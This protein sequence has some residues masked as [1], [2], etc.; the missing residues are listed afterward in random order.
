MNEYEELRIRIRKTDTRRYLVLANGPVAAAS[1]ITLN[2]PA[3]SYWQ[4]FHQLLLEELGEVVTTDSRSTSERARD[5]GRDLFAA[6]LP[7]PLHKALVESRAI[8]QQEGKHLRL[9]F[10][11]DADLM[12]LPLELLCAP[13]ADPLGRLALQS[14]LSIARSLEGAP[15]H[16]LRMPRT[17]DDRDSVKLLAVVCSPQRLSSLSGKREIE[18]LKKALPPLLVAL[19]P[20]P[21]QVLAGER[22]VV[23]RENVRALLK[24]QREPCALLIVAHGIYDDEEGCSAVLMEREDRTIDRLSGEI[25]NGLLTQAS[26]LRFVLLNLCLGAKASAAEPFSGLAQRLIAGGIPAVVAMQ[27]EVSNE[28]ATACSPSLFNGI[29]ENLIVDEA[30][31]AARLAM[32]DNRETRIE[33]ANPVLFLHRDFRHGWLFKVQETPDEDGGELPDPLMDCRRILA[34]VQTIPNVSNLTSA[35]R[36]KKLQGDWDGALRFAMAG[37]NANPRNPA[38]SRLAQEAKLESGLQNLIR[39]C[40]AIAGYRAIPD[41]ARTQ[42]RLR[43]SLPAQVYSVVSEELA[44][45]R[46]L[47]EEYHQ[48]RKDQKKGDWEEAARGYWDIL[49]VRRHRGDTYERFKNANLERRLKRFYRR[50][51]QSLNLEHWDESGAYF[52]RVLALRPKGFRDAELGR[53]YAE[54]R[55]AEVAAQEEGDWSGVGKSYQPLAKKK[56]RDSAQRHVYARGRAAEQRSTWKAA[57]K[58]YRRRGLAK[59]FPDVAWRLPYVRAR[60]AEAD[61]DWSQAVEIYGAL[62]RDH[63]GCRADVAARGLHALGRQAE[64]DEKWAEGLAVYE[65]LLADECPGELRIPV[66]TV[67]VRARQLEEGGEWARPMRIYAGPAEELPEARQRLERLQV[68][69]EAVPWAEELAIAGWTADPWATRAGMN[70]YADLAAADIRPGSSREAVKN[71]SFVLMERGAMTPEARTAW[72]CLR[73]LPERLRADAFL[74]RLHDRDELRLLLASIAPGPRDQ[75]LAGMTN[76]LP[77]ESPLFLL[78]GERRVEAIEFWKEL[79]RQNPADVEVVH[80]LALAFLFQAREQKAEDEHEKADLAWEEAL[81]CWTM[82]LSDDAYWERRRREWADAYQQTVT[83]GDLARLRSDLVQEILKGLAETARIR[84]DGGAVERAAELNRLALTFEVELEG[85]RSLKEAG[86]LGGDLADGGF[87]SGPIYL[88]RVALGDRLGRRISSLESETEGWK[89]ENLLTTLDTALGTGGEGAGHTTPEALFRLRCTFS[90]LGVTLLLLDRHHY[91]ETIENLPPLYRCKLSDLPDDC[92]EAGSIELTDAH[93]RTCSKC[94]SFLEEN[95]AYLC[96]DHRHA[97][98]LQ[99]AVELATR[100]HLGRA[101][102]ALAAG[103]VEAALGGWR[104]AIEISANAGAQVRTKRA[105]ARVVLGRAEVL[106]QDRSRRRGERLSE[107]IELVEQA[108]RLIGRADEGRLETRL[109]KLL[110]SRGVWYGYGCFKYQ[111]PD[112][113]KAAEDLRAALELDPDSLHARDNLSRALIVHANNLPED[114]VSVKALRLFAEAFTA[115]H[116]GLLRSGDHRQLVQAFRRGL[117]ELEGI[118]LFE[119][120]PEQLAD[121]IADMARSEPVSPALRPPSGEYGIADVVNLIIA[122]RRDGVEAPLRQALLDAVANL[123]NNWKGNAT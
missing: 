18:Q 101:Q 49:K 10:E 40:D 48:A 112:Y 79:R 100:A 107:A 44:E 75:V 46:R 33:W 28:A 62:E 56:Y 93:H 114:G 55:L 97:R 83:S 99:D 64:N 39:M 3:G 80:A 1:V 60:T 85:A 77:Q 57:T 2:R 84:A 41:L 66:R 117:D 29:C 24:R 54:G 106:S 105:I 108:R 73:I 86:G 37:L 13:E 9:R 50:A 17:D 65:R 51:E 91:D 7:E 36:C 31:S 111:D 38:C 27:G 45:A 102:E 103:R 110:T 115:L 116:E 5:L 88:G 72:D 118:I 63:S 6:L 122:I 22:Q 94:R 90:K 21:L 78:L 15:H 68:L 104:Q 34:D 43:A 95:P 121:R 92:P 14:D 8:A 12:Q 87:V 98:L 61:S 23:S 11:V 58:S 20:E 25:L 47:D 52:K 89:R 69:Q 123:A 19:D 71:S 76:A 35:A 32:A 59:T 113:E 82:V 74:Y 109:A 70:P 120:S 30:V 53:L 119:L 4:D 96:L 67:Y 81:A 42:K 16:P 26:G